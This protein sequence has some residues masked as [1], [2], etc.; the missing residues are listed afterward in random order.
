MTPLRKARFNRHWTLHDVSER[1]V[2]LGA[3]R[4]DTGNLSRVERG[5]QR[6]SISLAENLCQVFDGELTE[7]H[8]LYPER[9]KTDD[10]QACHSDDDNHH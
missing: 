7:L 2:A 6:A 4:I 1:L 8:I 10:S 5:E 9:Y 3:D